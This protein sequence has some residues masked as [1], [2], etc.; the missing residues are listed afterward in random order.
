VAFELRGAPFVL[1]ISDLS[2]P[3]ALFNLPGGGF[4]K[5]T[6]FNVLPLIMVF[7]F[8][9]Q[10]KMSSTVPKDPNDPQYKQQQMMAKIFPLMFGFIFY[11]MQSGLTLYFTFS[12]LLRILQQ[13]WVIKA[14]DETPEKGKT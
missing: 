14:H 12:T 1:W 2:R 10:Q 8:Y 13:L 7:T 5:F 11:T 4:W 6:T 9:F 3:D